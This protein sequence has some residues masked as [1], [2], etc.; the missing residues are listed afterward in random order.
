MTHRDVGLN[1]GGLLPDARPGTV[2]VLAI[3]CGVMVANVYLCQPL[4]DEIAR[5]LGVPEHVA[6]FVAVATQIGYALGILFVVPLGDMAEPRKLVRGLIAVTA[7]GLL[8]AAI[9]PGI[10]I[11]LLASMVIAAATVVAQVLIPLAASLAPLER[12]GRVI[13]ALQTGLILGI[14]FSR[15]IAGLI[16]S[17]AGT[18][19]APY[20]VAATATGSLLLILPRFMPPHTPVRERHSYGALLRSLPP[21]L[22]YRALLV[23]AG[24]GF[25]M[26]GAFSA[27]WANLAFHLA[28][29]AFGLGVAAAGLF[30]VWGAPGAL[31]AP[32]G[33]RLSDRIGP[34]WV[35]LG[36]VLCAGLAFIVASTAGAVSVLALVLAVNLLDFGV[37]CSQVANQARIFALGQA[38]RSRLNTVYMV[39]VFAGGAFG[40][41]VGTYAWSVAGWSGVCAVS[42]GLVAIAIIILAMAARDARR[43]AKRSGENHGT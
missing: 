36:A 32:I 38:I 8:G 11:L 33:G 17:V 20:F 9:A 42:G 43:D 1:T 40:S 35:N 39:A 7:L 24:L 27:F 22:Q 26:F 21:L 15:T 28:S 3:A 4:L 31:L 13:G 41:M 16:A 2:L 29:P 25:C 18:W 23:S 6:G 19:R 14:L 30:G 37:Q 5:G 12:R 34:D 10:P